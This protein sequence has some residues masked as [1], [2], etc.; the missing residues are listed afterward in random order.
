MK[1]NFRIDFITSKFYIFAPNFFLNIKRL[2]RKDVNNI[3]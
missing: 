1:N 2:L 3:L